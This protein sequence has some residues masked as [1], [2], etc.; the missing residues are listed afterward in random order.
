MVQEKV[1]RTA[2]DELMTNYTNLIKNF[3]LEDFLKSGVDP[4]RFKFNTELWGLKKSVRKEIE[5]KIEMKLENLM[6]DFHED[7]LG[8][9][10]D[11]KTKNSWRIVPKGELPGVDIANEKDDKFLQIKSKHNSMNSSSSNKLAEEIVELKNQ[12]PKAQIGCG[13]VIAKSG[14]AAIGESTIRSIGGLVFKGKEL[15]HFVTNNNKEMDEVIESFPI[16][17]RQ[18]KNN[19]N[20]DELLNQASERIINELERKAKKGGISLEDYLYRDAVG[21]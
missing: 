2:V 4:F 16:I 6:G 17:V 8:N 7:Y 14:Q 21:L 3:A 11:I 10:T 20:F 12:K 18:L 5:H 15:Y 9:T 13:F 19:Y 1:L